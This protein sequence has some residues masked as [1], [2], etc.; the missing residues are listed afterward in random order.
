MALTIKVLLENHKAAGVDNALKARPGL[1][2][3][4]QDEST[5]ILFDTGPDDSF[6]QNAS[7]MRIDL[8]DISAVVLSHGHY[9]HCG[10]V[11][12]LPDNSRIIC[13]PEMARERY[14]AITLPGM[15]RKIKKLSREGD[16]SRYRM[17][18]TRD[19]MPIS[20]KFIWSGE[21]LLPCLKPTAFLVVAMQS[22][23]IFQMRGY[24][25]TSRRKV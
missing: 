11:P 6:L 15:T 2:L 5:S 12:W 8:S 25:F 4:V 22:R 13:H 14:A 24:S 3:L 10:G 20:D 18:Y 23:I 19:P 1:S 17:V 21:I 7:T 16:Y 9:D